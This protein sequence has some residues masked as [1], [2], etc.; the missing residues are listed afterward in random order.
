M[1]LP[2]VGSQEAVDS[3]QV[4]MTKSLEDFKMNIVLATTNKKKIEEIKKIFGPMDTAS[5]V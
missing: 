2:L 3:E 4:G 5:R 1:S